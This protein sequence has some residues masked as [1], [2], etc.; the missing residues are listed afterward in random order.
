MLLE[1]IILLLAFSFSALIT[2]FIP[3]GY[4]LHYWVPLLLI[5]PGY[6][7]GMLIMWIVLGFFA[8]PFNKKK[9]YEKPSKWALFWLQEALKYINMH[10]LV[11]LKI[12]NQKPLPREKVLLVCNHRSKFDPMIL[13][14]IYGTKH[15]LA[16]ISKPTNFKIPIG[17]RLMA[18]SS[19]MAIDRYDKLKSLETINRAIDL[20]KNDY[21]SVGVFPE[22]TRS[23]DNKMGPFHEGVFAIAKHTNAP[24]VIVSFMGTENI[25][26]NFP[27]KK[28]EVTLNIVD[29]LYPENYQDMIVKEISDYCY[30]KMNKSLT[31]IEK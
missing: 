6:L 18:G 2:Y 9:F 3:T 4:G 10:A 11:D 15:S 14:A 24:I 17:G 25:H 23:E 29:I 12:V 28:T 30:E 22:G 1:I 31:D 13:A 19:Y 27:F 16:F 8:L 21:A 5:I 7:I 20:I 26:K